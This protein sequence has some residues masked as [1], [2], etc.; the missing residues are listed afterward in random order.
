MK[1]REEEG[2]KKER[3]WERYKE[4][5]LKACPEFKKKKP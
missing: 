1:E 4:T 5:D 3:K 2:D